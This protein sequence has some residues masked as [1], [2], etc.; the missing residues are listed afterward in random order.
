MSFHHAISLSTHYP[1]CLHFPVRKEEGVAG[2]FAQDCTYWAVR[3]SVDHCK[4]LSVILTERLSRL[5][6]R[7]CRCVD[8]RWSLHVSSRSILNAF[9]AVSPG[10]FS[11]SGL[12]GYYTYECII[13]ASGL[14]LA[15][16]GPPGWCPCRR[17]LIPHIGLAPVSTS[18]GCR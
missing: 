15:S 17:R 10:T 14:Q 4:W 2:I 3:R 16:L 13:Q 8:F 5:V 11:I 7:G 12:Q 6:R 1:V 9:S 18:A